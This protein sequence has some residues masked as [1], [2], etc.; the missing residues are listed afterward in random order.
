MASIF[1]KIVRGDIPSF[2]IAEDDQYY[3]F[4][5]IR[6][7]SKGHTLVIP[8]EEVDYI[9]D[10]PDELLAGLMVYAKKVAKALEAVVPCERI[11]V[12]V[13]GL[14]VPHAHVHLMPIHSISDLSFGKPPVEMSAE[15]MTALASAVGRHI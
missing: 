10:L 3:A 7:M 14:E 9:F 6:P 1:T 15:E 5:D 8:K 12:A 4:L 11:G 13:I 2:K